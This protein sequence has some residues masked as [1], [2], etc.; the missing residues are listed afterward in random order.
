[1]W[2]LGVLIYLLM[3]IT[4]FMGYVLPWGQMSFW[5]ATVITNLLGAFPLVGEPIREWL[6][7]GFAVGNPTLNRFFS[8]HYLLPFM[9]AGVVVLHV[10]ALH[11]VRN[12]NPV[13]ID[14][15][16]GADTLPFHP[17]YTMKDS[18]ALVLFGLLFAW[19]VFF[20]PDAMG[21]PD[22]YIQANALE[23]PEHIVPEWYLLVPYAILRAI[24]WKLGGV[25][26]MFGSIL[27]LFFLPWLDRS[28]VR[29]AR[30]RPLY[31]FF[32]VVFVAVCLGL[33]WLC[34]QP[35]EGVYVFWARLLSLYYF[36]FFLVLMPL[37]AKIE[38]PRPVPDSIL[39]PVLTPQQ[40]GA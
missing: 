22:N 38:K 7:G 6:W 25:L 24:P 15:K 23:T 27:V 10:W 35:A 33:G 9:I 5:A 34:A 30:Y 39:R 12:N 26:A 11:A 1:L 8:L 17:F 16:A 40:E 4:A 37:L 2:I 20:D 36:G 18:F 28:P 31:R 29:S 32:F 21:H 14:V 19:F 13:G 3:I